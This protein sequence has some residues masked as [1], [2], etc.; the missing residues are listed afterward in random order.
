VNNNRR[1]GIYIR[2]GCGNSQITNNNIRNNGDKGIYLDMDSGNS[3]IV[4]NYVISNSGDGVYLMDNCPNSE[5]LNN[6]II[7]NGG[8]GV[9]LSSSKESEI[10]NN[11]IDSNKNGIYLSSSGDS[12]I[13]NNIVNGSDGDGL[14]LDNSPSNNITYNNITYNKNCGIYLRSGSGLNDIYHNCFIDNGKQA[15]ESESSNTFD[16]GAEIGGNYWSDHVCD[17]DPSNGSQPYIIPPYG[18]KDR[19]PFENVSGWTLIPTPTGS[20][21]TGSGG[22]PSIMGNHTGTI[23]PNH[24]VIATKMYTYPCSG[25][26]GH[27]EYVKIWNSTWNATAIWDGYVGDWH[28]I[29]F[30]CTV[31]L[32]ENKKY[33]YTIITGSYPQI[34]HTNRLEINDGEITCA[35]FIDA[36]GKR[37]NNWIPAIRLE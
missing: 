18:H 14:Y 8:Y 17:G 25:T 33:N 36:N 19:Y 24:T 2:W 20:F 37:H 10:A 35:A 26:G 32:L 13:T 21:D 31:V 23:K 34:H 15:E 29:T 11:N 16:K 30:D 1:Y 22:Y 9:Y 12:K 4:N 7:S 3:K 6:E 28:N 5:I 27:T